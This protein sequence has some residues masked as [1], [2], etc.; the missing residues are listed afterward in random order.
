[1][2]QPYRLPAF[3]A[4]HELALALHAAL[5]RAAV[6]PCGLGGRMQR[7]AIAAAAAIVRA[8]PLPPERRRDLLAHARG[9]LHELGYALDLAERFG[10]F[11]LATAVELLEFQ[12]RACLTLAGMLG[13]IDES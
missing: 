1:M 6:D 10:T 8:A 5:A 11:D 3:L 12:T 13:E 2:A 9:R 7:S 4:A